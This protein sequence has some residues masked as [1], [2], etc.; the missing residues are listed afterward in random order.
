MSQSVDITLPV[1]DARR[2]QDYTVYVSFRL[3]QVQLETNRRR[4]VR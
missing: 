1:G 3:N 2:A 4:G